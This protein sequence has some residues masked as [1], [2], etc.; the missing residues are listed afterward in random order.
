MK[1]RA[2]HWLLFTGLSIKRPSDWVGMSSVWMGPDS[3]GYVLPGTSSDECSKGT[4]GMFEHSPVL[5]LWRWCSGPTAS[6]KPWEWRWLG[7][8]NKGFGLVSVRNFVLNI[9]DSRPTFY[10]LV[11]QKDNCKRFGECAKCLFYKFITL[12][13]PFILVI[14]WFWLFN[15]CWILLG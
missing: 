8:K 4:H 11:C 15:W 14:L 6:L 3:H 12:W 10:Y 5:Q 9:K 1:W 13:T 7:R 2:V